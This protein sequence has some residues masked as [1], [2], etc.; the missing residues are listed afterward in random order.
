MSNTFAE[1]TPQ[2]GDPV[3]LTTREDFSMAIA[4]EILKELECA[5]DCEISNDGWKSRGYGDLVEK[6]IPVCLGNVE[7]EIMCSYEHIFIKRISGN[8][9]KFYEICERIRCTDYAA[10]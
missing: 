4:T 2:Y 8:M 6:G 7:F 1:T 10:T 5:E 9:T 3:V